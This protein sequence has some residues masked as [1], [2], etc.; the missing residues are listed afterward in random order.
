MEYIRE[1][2]EEINYSLRQTQDKQEKEK[3]GLRAK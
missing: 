1:I 2:F 3:K